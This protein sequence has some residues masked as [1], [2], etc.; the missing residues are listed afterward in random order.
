MCLAPEEIGIGWN[1]IDGGSHSPGC[2]SWVGAG[3][4]TTDNV[5]PKDTD[6][7]GRM[8]KSHLKCISLVYS[9]NL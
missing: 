5:V 4:G 8:G 7:E 9:L 3:P 1:L 6:L 2:P